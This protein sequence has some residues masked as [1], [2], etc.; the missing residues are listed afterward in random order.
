ELP[1]YAPN[2]LVMRYLA[3]PVDGLASGGDFE[4][5]DYN[6]HFQL[7]A[8]GQPSLGASIG[9]PLGA[10]VYGGISALWGD[11]L[12]DRQIFGA[13]Q[14]NGTVK[15]IGGAVQYYNL[16]DRWNWGASAMHLAYP[17]VGATVS[18][19]PDGSQTL[20]SLYVQRL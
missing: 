12:G 17:Y 10:G 6:S 14:A 11:Q 2:S 7:D 20:V 13:L 5:T 9:G 15:D 4:V 3:D 16:R 19:S 1:P 18:P 8:I